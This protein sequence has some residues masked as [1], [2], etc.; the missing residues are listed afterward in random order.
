MVGECHG[1]LSVLDVPEQPIDVDHMS[2]DA[3]NVDKVRHFSLY[4]VFDAQGGKRRKAVLKS[5][6]AVQPTV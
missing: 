2:V 6:Q 1:N 5:V 3:V 4:D